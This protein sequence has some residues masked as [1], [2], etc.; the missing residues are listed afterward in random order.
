MFNAYVFGVILFVF[1]IWY[2]SKVVV[3]VDLVV[4]IIVCMDF[5]DGIV[6]N[7]MF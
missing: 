1:F 5:L 6:L 3:I 2:F 4:M 7:N